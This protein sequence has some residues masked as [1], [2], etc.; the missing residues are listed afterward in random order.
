VQPFIKK[1]IKI[2]EVNF[3]NKS[4]NP[5]KKTVSNVY[6]PI[7]RRCIKER[8]TGYRTYFWERFLGGKY[9]LYVEDLSSVFADMAYEDG[10]DDYD[11][12]DDLE[13]AHDTTFCRV[14]KHPHRGYGIEEEHQI[15]SVKQ[16]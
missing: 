2:E 8:F 4:K 13:R 7:K 5:E 15:D 14:L 11:P 1:I 6:V 3:T 10:V 9:I 12:K 16:V